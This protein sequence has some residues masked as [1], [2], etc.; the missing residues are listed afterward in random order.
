MVYPR[1][2]RSYLTFNLVIAVIMAIVMAVRAEL[3]TGHF[4]LVDFLLFAFYSVVLSSLFFGPLG[5]VELY[6]Y[7]QKKGVWYEWKNRTRHSRR[8]RAIDLEE[9]RHWKNEAVRTRLSRGD[10]L[11]D[12]T[13]DRTGLFASGT[14][15]AVSR[16]A[17]LMTVAD[18]FEREGKREA[19]ER[20][21][22]QITQRFANSPQAAVATR[23]LSS[24][25][26]F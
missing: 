6:L 24:A 19:A 23:R 1:R 9:R 18:R 5:I 3:K 16:P 2:I 12:G 25:T 21:Y 17:L 8:D 22:L 15:D 10:L 26:S 11:E 7:R 4:L 20:C 13:T 14:A